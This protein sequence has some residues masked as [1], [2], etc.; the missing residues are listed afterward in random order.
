MGNAHRA[1]GDPGA[2][3]QR[4]T[5]AIRESFI[6]WTEWTNFAESCQ[7]KLFVLRRWCERW[8][9]R[10]YHPLRNSTVQCQHCY[11]VKRVSWNIRSRS[12]M[13]LNASQIRRNIRRVAFRSSYKHP[14]VPISGPRLN[15]RPGS[16]VPNRSP[17]T[18]CLDA[19]FWVV[20]RDIL[21]RSRR[22]GIQ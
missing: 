8:E 15:A 12:C 2:S 13:L 14:F 3:S 22:S 7:C 5:T 1:K 21:S 19:S 20:R 6:W 4:A 17:C 16:S 10:C 18:A 9:C 11:C